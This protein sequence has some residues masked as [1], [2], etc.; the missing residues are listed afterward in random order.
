MKSPDLDLRGHFK[1]DVPES[2]HAKIEETLASLPERK[3]ESKTVPQ[4]KSL[5]VSSHFIRTFSAA[6]CFILVMAVCYSIGTKGNLPIRTDNKPI[7]NDADYPSEIDENLAA[8]TETVISR[9]R[10]EL[11]DGTESLHIDTETVTSTEDWF[12]L[13]LS[14]S[15][16]GTDGDSGFA[17]YR[18][19]DRRTDTPVTFGDLFG[20]DGMTAVAEIA[21]DKMKEKMA[22]DSEMIY[23]VDDITADAK[24]I[25]WADETSDPGIL[26]EIPDDSDSSRPK[27]GVVIY[28]SPGQKIPCVTRNQN[29][30]FTEDGSLVLVYDEY[31]VAPGFM[32]CP[33]IVISEEEYAPYLADR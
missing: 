22:A 4:K 11:G 26:I 20:E 12:T 18:H 6:A 1:H 19:I 24:M 28:P 30:Y 3:A 31:T 21:I 27:S 9:F 17:Q 25:L 15:E 29:F 14:V 23:W 10:S 16:N 5:P 8:L 2:V 32:G 33:E 13:K 7:S